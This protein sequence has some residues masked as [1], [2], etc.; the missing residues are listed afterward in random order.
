MPATVGTASMDLALD[1]LGSTHTG[2]EDFFVESLDAE[3]QAV[4]V[5][6]AIVAISHP[7]LGGAGTPAPQGIAVKV[8]MVLKRPGLVRGLEFGLS[9]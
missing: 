4:F 8:R 7:E 2:I 9:G 1:L 5:G 3:W 6:P